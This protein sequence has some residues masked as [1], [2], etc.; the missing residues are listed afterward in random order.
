[1]LLRQ[2]LTRVVRHKDQ[3]SFSLAWSRLLTYHIHYY[4]TMLDKKTSRTNA[5]AYLHRCGEEEFYKMVS[6]EIKK[7]TKGSTLAESSAKA[8]SYIQ[9]LSALGLDNKNFL[10]GL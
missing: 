5:L 9:R 3:R 2:K 4:T 10:A 7:S 8:T 6:F 1:L